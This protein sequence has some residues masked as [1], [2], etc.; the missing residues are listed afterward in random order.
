MRTAALLF[1]LTLAA[2]SAPMA[3]SGAAT[4]DGRV[5][6]AVTGEGVSGARVR[7]RPV[8]GGIRLATVST[9]TGAFHFEG[10]AEGRYGIQVEHENYVRGLGRGRSTAFQSTVDLSTGEKRRDLSVRIQPNGSVE[11]MV[12]AESGEPVDQCNVEL[13][14]SEHGPVQRHQ[15]V[16]YT[17]ATDDRGRFRVADVAPG[18]YSLR[19]RCA[20][21]P[22]PF[23]PLLP[24]KADFAGPS[25]GFA[26][27]LAPGRVTVEAG[28][29][30]RGLTVQVRDSMLYPVA[31]TATM[32]ITSG[33]AESVQIVL[34]PES[35]DEGLAAGAAATPAN[36]NF[37]VAAALPGRYELVALARAGEAL[38]TARRSV[39]VGDDT[40]PISVTLSAG[41]E[42]RGTIE[43]RSAGAGDPPG[44]RVSGALLPAEPGVFNGQALES[45]DAGAFVIRG[46]PPGRWRLMLPSPDP[47]FYLQSIFKGKD[48]LTSP[49]VAVSDA[50]PLR[51]VFSDGAGG[52]DGVVQEPNN[53]QRPSERTIVLQPLFT[54]S[55][56]PPEQLVTTAG[57]DGRFRFGGMAPNRYRLYVLP[58]LDTEV[59]LDPELLRALEAYS[60]LVTVGPGRPTAVTA[61]AVPDAAVS[62]VLGRE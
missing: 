52:I 49:E 17:G 39:T 7:I 33:V 62:A 3:Q 20:P 53:A 10:L 38:Y 51:V 26:P 12:I 15:E 19:A 59:A 11:G 36:P 54:P 46:V 8:A 16:K 57:A 61:T 25:L 42:V 32:P 4:L 48:E 18:S 58:G 6:N 43:I 27:A 1:L 21:N 34:L 22:V 41:I 2:P 60:Q 45:D 55:F 40:P 37:R 35:A 30:S 9:A 14:Q 28:L 5:V 44:R 56:L 50:A 24:D 13:L 23:R 47:G 29:A 31:G